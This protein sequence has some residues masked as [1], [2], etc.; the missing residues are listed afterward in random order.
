MFW[1]G[2]IGIDGFTSF[3][4]P[5]GL[6]TLCP[7]GT[8]ASKHCEFWTSDSAHDS[9]SI[10]CSNWPRAAA[11]SLNCLFGRSCWLHSPAWFSWYFSLVFCWSKFSWGL[12][13]RFRFQERVWC[14]YYC[15]WMELGMRWVR[16][17]T[18]VGCFRRRS[19]PCVGS[20]SWYRPLWN[21]FW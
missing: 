6:G 12:S 5:F 9:G 17:R 4:G 18:G 10:A 13:A 3:W 21:R 19:R 7:E 2:C 20:S 16:W 15:E 14:I 8:A 1:L 11:P